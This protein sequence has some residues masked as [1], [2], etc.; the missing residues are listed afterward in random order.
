MPIIHRILVFLVYVVFGLA[1]LNFVFFFGLV[2][3]QLLWP[4]R[5]APGAFVSEAAQVWISR[6]RKVW[7]TCWLT[8]L[9]LV[10]LLFLNEGLRHILIHSDRRLNQRPPVDAGSALCLH[11]EA[12]RPGATE[13]D[14]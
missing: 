14:C 1:V 7:K 3:R 11:F 13:A 8:M 4:G 10:V 5:I 9:L 12:Q 2:L 6:V